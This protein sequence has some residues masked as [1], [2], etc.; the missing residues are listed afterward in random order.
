MGKYVAVFKVVYSDLTVV[1]SDAFTGRLSNA[2][3][4]IVSSSLGGYSKLRR[5]S[6]L[7]KNGVC[8]SVCLVGLHHQQ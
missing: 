7:L 5:S 6:S 8:L 3:P 1:F 2:T 4:N